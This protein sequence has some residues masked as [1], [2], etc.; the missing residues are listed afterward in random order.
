MVVMMRYLQLVTEG[1]AQGQLCSVPKKNP[2]V[3]TPDRF[4][5]IYKV[6]KPRQ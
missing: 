2:V 1:A 5:F 6:R 4:E 3:A